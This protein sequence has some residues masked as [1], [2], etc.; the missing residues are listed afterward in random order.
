MRSARAEVV[1]HHLDA[2][3]RGR[4][5]QPGGWSPRG[6]GPSRRRSRRPPWPSSRPRGSRRPSSSGRRRSDVA[7]TAREGPSTARS[8]SARISGV[9]ASSQSTPASTPTAAVSSASSSD[10]RSRESWTIGCVRL[11]ERHGGSV[12]SRA[13]REIPCNTVHPAGRGSTAVAPINRWL[14]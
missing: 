9:P 10:V 13:T 1:S 7:G 12:A 6:P 4:R 11:I 2:E 5:R 14:C 3:R 8:P